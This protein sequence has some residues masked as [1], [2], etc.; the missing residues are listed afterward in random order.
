MNFDLYWSLV[1]DFY[2]EVKNKKYIE[3]YLKSME[4]LSADL[5]FYTKQ[6]M[7][8]LGL[9][10]AP[11]AITRYNTRLTTEQVQMGNAMDMYLVDIYTNEYGFHVI[12]VIPSQIY[13]AR[14]IP[15]DG[16]IHFQGRPIGYSSTNVYKIKTARNNI[17]FDLIELMVSPTDAGYD[18][19][20][21]TMSDSF[22]S[23]SNWTQVGT[24]TVVA[25]GDLSV[26]TTSSVVLVYD[27]TSDSTEYEVFL[28]LSVNADY[29]A[30]SFNDKHFGIKQ[31]GGNYYWT[32]DGV[33][34]LMTT[35]E[36]YSVVDFFR[37]RIKYS[38][39]F[40]FFYRNGTN[41]FKKVGVLA[42]TTDDGDEARVKLHITNGTAN[43][44]HLLINDYQN[45]CTLTKL[46][47]YEYDIDQKMIEADYLMDRAHMRDIVFINVSVN[48]N[49]ASGELRDDYIPESYVPLTGCIYFGSDKF[50]YESFSVSSSTYSFTAEQS[51]PSTI[52]TVSFNIKNY[53]FTH[54]EDFVFDEDNHS[55]LNSYRELPET[56]WAPECKI[57]YDIIQNNYG[58]LIDFDANKSSLKYINKV[59]GAWAALMGGA[60]IEKVEV[61]VLSALG[62]PVATVDGIVTVVEDINDDFG[63]LEYKRAVIDGIEHRLY[64]NK[65]IEF[66]VVVGQRIHKFQPLTTGVELWDYVRSE[67]GMKSFF[68]GST[69]DLYNS[70]VVSIALEAMDSDSSIEDV[71]NFLKKITP[72]RLKLFVMFTLLDGN[73]DIHDDIS[74]YNTA[75][76]IVEMNEDMAFDE[77]DPWEQPKHLF[78]PDEDIWTLEDNHRLGWAGY[79]TGHLGPNSIWKHIT[80]LSGAYSGGNKEVYE[81][82]CD[83]NTVAGDIITVTAILTGSEGRRLKITKTGDASFYAERYVT[84]VTG[85]N[86]LTYSGS[87]ITGT[88]IIIFMP[89]VAYYLGELYAS[90]INQIKRANPNELVSAVQII[91]FG[92]VI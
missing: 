55:R 92:T 3:I 56:I 42:K 9:F 16:A 32:I 88:D 74:D 50:F 44:R 35:K 43:I 85:A 76:S 22:N 78:N 46:H 72:S 45:E 68:G 6:L 7:Q 67:I 47:P 21:N 24:G 64:A 63:A 90:P 57:D 82:N 48:D 70:F 36:K 83:A 77:R 61:G 41:Q 20:A 66:D 27:K 38:E 75:L 10:Q 26:D 71:Y 52:D 25:D 86:Q 58:K 81:E 89:P 33:D 13:N 18:I 84:A 91:E 28:D 79:G 87:A 17:S 73:E 30:I 23:L 49:I 53:V 37:L 2:K 31:S 4:D 14:L 39:G 54:N 34:T 59:R 65:Q 51:F 8:G 62:A 69:P 1:G 11:Y 19:T 80:F 15:S 40:V 12:K 60:T 29:F 5:W